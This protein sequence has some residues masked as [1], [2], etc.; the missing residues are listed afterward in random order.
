[1]GGVDGSF[2]FLLL[3]RPVDTGLCVPAVTADVAVFLAEGVAGFDP[4]GGIDVFEEDCR[5]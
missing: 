5:R 3:I 4:S 1:M 2:V